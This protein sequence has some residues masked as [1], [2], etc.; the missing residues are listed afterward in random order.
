M[1][2]LAP[3]F[4]FMVFKKI[5]FLSKDNDLFG[6]VAYI[7]MNFYKFLQIITDYHKLQKLS[8]KNSKI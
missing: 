2:R 5:T 7:L 3:F 1:V 8:K 4:I 6:F